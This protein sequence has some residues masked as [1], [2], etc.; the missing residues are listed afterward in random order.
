MEPTML[1]R[2]ANR[3]P[4]MHFRKANTEPSLHFR[5]A[6]TETKSAR[7][8]FSLGW[9]GCSSGFPLAF[10]LVKS[11]GAALPALGKTRASLFFYLD[12]LYLKCFVFFAFSIAIQAGYHRF[13]SLLPHQIQVRP[14][15]IFVLQNAIQESDCQQQQCRITAKYA[16]NGIRGSAYKLL[17]LGY[18]L[19]SF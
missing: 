5:R 8:E 14:F 11:L 3:K 6:N 2:R 7:T 13:Y 17:L 15:R 18:S 1:F 16:L 9:Q 19:I 4:S 12:P 10:A